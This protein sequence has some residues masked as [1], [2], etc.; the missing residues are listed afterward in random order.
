M[1]QELVTANIVVAGATGAGKST[2]L[3]AIF[4]K[5]LARTGT[6]RPV[7]S[8]IVEYSS[9]DVPVRIWDTVGLELS[10]ETTQKTA[11]DIKQTILKRNSSETGS[12]RYGTA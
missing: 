1:Y 10:P 6:G 8:S 11:E 9:P 5:D 7:T 12:M 4:G 2:L 3:N